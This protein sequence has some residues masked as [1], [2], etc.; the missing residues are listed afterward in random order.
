MDQHANKQETLACTRTT[1]AFT[2]RETVINQSAFEASLARGARAPTC[3]ETGG[4]KKAPSRG[5]LA[6][7]L[8]GSGLNSRSSG[9]PARQRP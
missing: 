3:T 4:T 7:D 1:L 9:V 8:V 5:V 6:S 2:R